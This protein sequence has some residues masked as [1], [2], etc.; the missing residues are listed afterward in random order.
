M[1]R[2]AASATSVDKSWTLELAD[3]IADLA[4]SP[5]HGR[6][7]AASATGEIALIE[8][9]RPL[10]R[11]MHPGGVLSRLDWS[12]DGQLLASGGADGQV[13]LWDA[14]TGAPRGDR[15]AGA[16]W[17]DHLAFSPDGGFLAAAAGKHLRVWTREGQLALSCDQHPSTI[18]A[19]DWQR[20]GR[21]LLTSCYRGVRLFS[22]GGTEPRQLGCPGSLISAAWSPNGRYV[23]AGSQD[24]EVH[25]W[26]LK[27]PAPPHMVMR[28]YLAKVN[29]LAW[30]G[31]S[32][33]VATAGGRDVVIWQTE[34]RG[35]GGSRPDT[36]KGHAARITALAFQHGGSLLASGASDGA[37]RIW[38][39][40]TPGQPGM[41]IRVGGEV[42]VLKWTA[43]GRRLLIGDRS[44]RI[45]AHPAA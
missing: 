37:V 35:P 4:S 13:W 39:A 28:G 42:T 27:P 8:G 31:D 12:P 32:R 45:T 40:A 22:L 20:D 23:C 6:V 1:P 10:Q 5:D 2:L 43:D 36:R 29:V 3:S 34:G 14:T 16:D 26:D 21:R 24:R 33:R 38:N 11:W 9:G 17:V 19:L 15:E 44:G 30:S 25:F 18:T 7:A 41:E